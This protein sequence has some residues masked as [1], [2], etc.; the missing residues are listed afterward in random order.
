MAPGFTNDARL[1]CVVD[2]DRGLRRARAAT[3]FTLALPGSM[4]LYQ[5]EELGL[6]EVIDLADDVRQ[7]PAWHRSGGTDGFRD[8]CRVPIPW[9]GD[10]PSYGFGPGEESWLPQPAEWAE[11]SVERERGAA[12][13]TLEMYRLALRI[14]RAAPSLGE[15]PLTWL[16]APDDVL[17]LRR[18]GPDGSAV[19]CAVNLG[20]ASVRLP[21]E[22]GVE[23]VAASSDDVAVLATDDGLE[24]VVMGSE[25]A[26]WLASTP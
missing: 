24:A 22:W 8:G 4:Y 7:D 17:A 10:A 5:G 11:L 26:L 9:S 18:T 25:T 15:G 2:E 12:G 13:S 16:E 20:E 6:P 3:L 23:V 19:T 14:R 1:T 21:A